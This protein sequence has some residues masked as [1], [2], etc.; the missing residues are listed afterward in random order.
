MPDRFANGDP[1]NDS[2]PDLNEQANRNDPWGRHG[3]DLQE[4]STTSII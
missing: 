4:L 2:D 1:T 3:G